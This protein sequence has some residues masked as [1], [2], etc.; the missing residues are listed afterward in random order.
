[1]TNT[2]GSNST[3]L[4][5]AEES[6]LKTLPGSPVWYGLEPN[7]Y[8]AFGGTISTVSR[9][10]I[11]V[12]RQSRKG[13]VTDLEVSAGWN[14]DLTFSNLTRLFQ[15]FF[16][17]DAREKM[18]TQNLGSAAITITSATASSDTYAAASGLDGFDPGHIVLASGFTKSANNGLKVVASASAAAL[19]V[20]NGL[21]DET[22][23]ASAKIEAVGFQFA[24]GDLTVT[25]TGGQIFLGVTAAD[26]TT[27]GL[28][29]GEWVFIGGDSAGTVFATCP[30]GFARIKTVAAK[31]IE[32]D[33]TTSTFATDTGAA[34]TIQMFFGKVI[35]NENTCALIKRR[36]YQLERQLS[37]TGGDVQSE[38]VVGAI[39]NELNI[40]TPAN[41]KASVDMTFVGCDV[42]H[43]TALEGVKAGTRVAQAAEDAINTS[44][45][46]YRIKMNI[47]GTSPNP[48]PLFAYVSDLSLSV[49]N[50][51]TPTKAIGVLGAF[52]ASTGNFAVSGS[53]TAFFTDVAAVAAIRANSDVALNAIFAKDNKGLIFDLPLLGLSNGQLQVEKDQPIKIPVDH[54]A[55]ENASGYTLLTNWFAYL[56][57]IAMPA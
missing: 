56:P 16:F 13:T 43:R 39:P 48:S 38:Y 3:S 47:V 6:S 14:Q 19:V 5:F 4:S 15:G 36:S 2:L 46:I 7:S 51:V 52:D 18:G 35:K 10:P 11:T 50:G 28:I 17:A 20:G 25:V 45:D 40:N 29:P 34:K 23:T 1:M 12:G 55:Y 21:A 33:D 49:A 44:S 9:E 42:E 8:S 24:A 27:L 57:N 37:C 26:F 32:L 30:S 41:D 54:T 53:V 31:Q 22:P